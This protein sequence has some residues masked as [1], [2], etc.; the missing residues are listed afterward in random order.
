MDDDPQTLKYVRDTLTN[1][2]Y[3]P[4]VT[5]DPGEVAHLIKSYKPQLVLLDLILPG[6][7]GIELMEDI[8][9]VD[10]VPVIF[11]SGYGRDE[12]VARALKWEHPI[13]WSSPF[14]QQSS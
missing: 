12:I 14:P 11:L 1:A 3:T 5:A 10:K 6:T 8:L 13:M 9:E 7:D 4:I 2:G